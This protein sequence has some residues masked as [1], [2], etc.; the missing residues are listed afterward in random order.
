MINVLSLP[1]AYAVEVS[2]LTPATN[3]YRVRSFSALHR[4][5][6]WLHTT[7][8]RAQFNW[9]MIANIHSGH[10][11]RNLTRH[12]STVGLALSS[13]HIQPHT[14]SYMEQVED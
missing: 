5:K 3:A 9:C 11:N 12:S 13:V 7:T 1:T 4:L 10:Y 14:V 8:D 2:S 6:T